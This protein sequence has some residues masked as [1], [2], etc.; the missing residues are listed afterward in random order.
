MA[1]IARRVADSV[2]GSEGSGLA[3]ESQHSLTWV[4]PSETKRSELD[5]FN[6]KCPCV[7]GTE[8]GDRF[9][10]SPCSKT[11]KGWYIADVI[12][13]CLLRFGSNTH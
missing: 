5:S 9:L 11:F 6:W 2:F 3:E 12:V 13:K 10:Y 4:L 7:D 1:S 8:M